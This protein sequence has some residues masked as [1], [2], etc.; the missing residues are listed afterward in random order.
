[1]ALATDNLRTPWDR[2][3]L[4][5]GGRDREQRLSGSPSRGWAP[6]FSQSLGLLS[7]LSP[8]PGSSIIGGMINAALGN[9]A[10][11]QQA[12]AMGMQPDGWDRISAA[13]GGLGA[14]RGGWSKGWGRGDMAT[15]G[16][17]GYVGALNAFDPGVGGLARAMGAGFADART[18]GGGRGFGQGPGG[19]IGNDGS[20]RNPGA[21]GRAGAGGRLGGGV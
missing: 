19:R 17:G 8:V 6:G 4:E 18:P 15:P 11:S 7:G 5:R 1:M 16:E 3:M 10:L 21:P 2:L 9:S 14:G 20:G 13:L 12:R